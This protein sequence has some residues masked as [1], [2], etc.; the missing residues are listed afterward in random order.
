MRRLHSIAAGLLAGVVLTAALLAGASTPAL[1]DA[2]SG[3]GPHACDAVGDYGVFDWGSGV[4]YTYRLVSEVHASAARSRYWHV[5]SSDPDG[6]GHQL[7]TYL[8]TC[9]DDGHTDIAVIQPLRYSGGLP[10]D[11]YIPVNA[12]DIRCLWL[13]DIASPDGQKWYPYS[14]W[15]LEKQEK[16]GGAWAAD[17]IVVIGQ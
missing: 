4:A 5:D 3:A 6:S 8:V 15:R 7:D 2:G 11:R 13:R 9:W 14:Y 12:K 10:C 1:A 16:P 17:E